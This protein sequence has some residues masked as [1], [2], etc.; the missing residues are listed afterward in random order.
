MT[1]I[2]ASLDKKVWYNDLL[3]SIS[4]MVQ[5]LMLAKVKDIPSL[6]EIENLGKKQPGKVYF[7][8]CHD[9]LSAYFS[10]DE[11]DYLDVVLTNLL[12]I[13]NKYKK[14]LL[15]YSISQAAVLKQ[16]SATFHDNTMN[17]RIKD[18]DPTST[19]NLS[20]PQLIVLI[21]SEVSTY[22]QNKTNSDWDSNLK[23]SSY[24]FNNLKEESDFE[25]IDLIY[26]DPPFVSPTS[27]KFGNYVHAYHILEFFQNYPY[28][29]ITQRKSD[30]A[31]FKF[32]ENYFLLQQNRRWLQPEFV[33]NTF[34]DL[35]S[36]GKNL[37]LSYRTD[38]MIKLTEIIDKI[39]VSFT[40][41]SIFHQPH[42]TDSGKKETYDDLLI[43]AY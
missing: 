29:D 8:I 30:S 39:R 25:N 24:D 3:P 2:L 31:L 32:K 38:S 4:S 26:A 19:W 42:L 14:L 17:W 20:F 16:G 40:K 15:Q 12:E 33:L 37:V 22:I 21:T 11:T 6:S 18:N 23:F 34:E 36:V 7:H 1:H 5:G 28:I 43:I 41:V 10:P 35:M 9:Y 27:G 13:E